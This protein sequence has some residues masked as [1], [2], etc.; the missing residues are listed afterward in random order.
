DT[1]DL[2]DSDI[3]AYL[4]DVELGE[5][6]AG[7]ADSTP[8][9]LPEE[10]DDSTG[11]GTAT[12]WGELAWPVGAADEDGL[13]ARDESEPE[14]VGWADE[15]PG[16]AASVVPAEEEEGPEAEMLDEAED[17]IDESPI[18][19]SPVAWGTRYRDAHQGWIEDDEGRSTW[20][21][22]VTSGQSVAGWDIDI[23]LGMVSGDVALN[24]PALENLAAEVAGARE[25]AGRRMLDEA[26]ARG[27]HAVVGV[28]FSIQE[29][30]GAVLVAASG[31][32]V[33]LRTPA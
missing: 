5:A 28:T 18:V 7:L 11:E 6:L 31:V 3:P 8:D 32:A 19:D 33:T 23:Y 10:I 26:L 4:S 9:H 17:V 13:E 27:A 30:A 2:V 25:A 20:R 15:E 24:Q 14:P 21:P 1:Q 16:L 29:V 22:I 12:G